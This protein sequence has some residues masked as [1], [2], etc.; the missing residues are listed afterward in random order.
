MAGRYSNQNAGQPMPR[1]TR[2]ILSFC[3]FLAAIVLGFGVAG[4][5]YQ[6]NRER[7]QQSDLMGAVICGQGQHVGDVPSG[8]KGRR[9]ICRDAGG[10]EIGGRNNF[11]FVNM[12]LPFIF[13]CGVPAVLLIWVTDFGEARRY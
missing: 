13:V 10:V 7:I 2:I 5:V 1:K 12:A 11:I 8:A 3:I 4:A 6:I 9:M